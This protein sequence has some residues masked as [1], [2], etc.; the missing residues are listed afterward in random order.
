MSLQGGLMNNSKERD[1]DR[2]EYVASFSMYVGI[3]LVSFVLFLMQHILSI[4]ILDDA[5]PTIQ[6]FGMTVGYS[7]EAYFVTAF[8]TLL[9]LILAIRMH[10]NAF[11]EIYTKE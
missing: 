2:V 1:L 9:H 7:F 5:N 10:R 11:K 4:I 3:T 8:S 6:A